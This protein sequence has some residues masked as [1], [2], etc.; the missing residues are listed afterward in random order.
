MGENNFQNYD[1]KEIER[2][3][4]FIHISY[5]DYFYIGSIART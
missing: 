3:F 4:N 5:T 2:N 1:M